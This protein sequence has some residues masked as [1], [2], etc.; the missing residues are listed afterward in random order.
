MT[1]TNF[2]V[3]KN[4][5]ISR[6]FFAVH[7]CRTIAELKINN[8]IGTSSYLPNATN[9]LG[10]LHVLNLT[11]SSNIYDASCLRRDV[12]QNRRLVVEVTLRRA[13]LQNVTSTVLIRQQ[14]WEFVYDSAED[15]DTCM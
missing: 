7:V 13:L 3:D 5:R 15:S 14:I 10:R 11:G 4:S 2:D 8:K 12:I 9:L 1:N 6:I